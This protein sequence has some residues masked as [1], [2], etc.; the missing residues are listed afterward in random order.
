MLGSTGPVTVAT[1]FQRVEE[2]Y[3]FP[4]T[5]TYMEMLWLSRIKSQGF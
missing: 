4:P 1:L 5:F 3:T 2:A